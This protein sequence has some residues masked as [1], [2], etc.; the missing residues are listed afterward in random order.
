M[1]IKVLEPLGIPQTDLEQI[2]QRAVG[3]QAELYFYP[4]RQEAED[5]LIERCQ[6]ADVVIL[7][8]F[9]FSGKVMQACPKLKYICV[10]F[11]G[12]DH[13]DMQAA[14]AAGITV[15]NCTGYSTVAVAELVIGFVLAHYRKLNAA[16]ATTLASLDKSGLMGQ[17]LAGKTFGIVGLGH[18]GTQ[19]AKLASAFGCEVLATARHE[20]QVPG[21]QMVD[22]PTLLKT[23]DIVSLHV[24]QNDTTK[25][26]IGAAE[27][28]LM[29]PN[30]LLVNAARGPIVNTAALIQALETGEIA[31]AC[32]DVFDQEPPLAPDDPLLKTK[33]LTLTPHIGFYTQEAMVKR[34]RQLGELLQAYLAGSPINVVS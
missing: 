14:K 8:N 15:S 4:D 29:K 1:L 11:T 24:P 2:L 17:E 34:A 6:D 16:H 27:L 30:A 31:G 23:S 28:S 18:I 19:L 13:V 21:V 10:A 26:L 32:L 5:V 12:Y 20:K 22:L 25:H 9:R 7:S 33:N 3:D